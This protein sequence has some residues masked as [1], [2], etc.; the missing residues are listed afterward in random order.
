MADYKRSTYLINPKFQIRFSLF[1]CGLIFLSS[2]IYPLTIYDLLTSYI[3]YTSKS[4]QIVAAQLENKRSGLLVILGL[5]QLGFLLIVFIISIFF[6]HKI[7]GPMYKLQK[8]L[9]EKKNNTTRDK[10]YFRK[11]DYF[12]EV[13]SDINEVFDQMDKDHFDDLVYLDEVKSYLGNLSMVIP[14]DKQAVLQEITSRIELIQERY[15][16]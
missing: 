5:W 4:S 11:G 16:R 6:S 7:A 8:F 15:N 2:L 3:E 9:R 1:F 10:L 12:Q 13:A 14:E